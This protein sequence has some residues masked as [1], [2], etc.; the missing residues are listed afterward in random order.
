MALFEQ[1]VLTIYFGLSSAL[2]KGSTALPKGHSPLA[3]NLWACMP[4][5]L[6]VSDLEKPLVFVEPCQWTVNVILP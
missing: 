3:S 2:A 4:F 5:Y 1:A 6:L